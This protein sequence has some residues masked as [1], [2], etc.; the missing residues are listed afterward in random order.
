MNELLG[1]CESLEGFSVDD[2][3]FN[4]LV[5]EKSNETWK[6]TVER[7]S[8]GLSSPTEQFNNTLIVLAERLY[9]KYSNNRIQYEI[10]N[11]SKLCKDKWCITIQELKDEKINCEERE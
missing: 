5:A 10:I 1:I 9:N 8:K 11:C 6:L 4:V 3:G 7:Y 2:L